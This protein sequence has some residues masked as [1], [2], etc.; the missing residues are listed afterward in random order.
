M[1]TETLNAIERWSSN[2]AMVRLREDILGRLVAPTMLDLQ[3]IDLR[4]KDLRG[5]DFSSSNLRF[6]RLDGSLV[7]A[8]RFASAD[9]TYGSFVEADLS[10]SDFAVASLRCAN[11]AGADLRFASFRDADLFNCILA[12]S[13][14]RAS[15]VR[16]ALFALSDLGGALTAGWR[17]ASEVTIEH[18]ELRGPATLHPRRRE[19]LVAQGLAW[20]ASTIDS[21]L[22]TAFRGTSWQSHAA[23]ALVMAM[24]YR[25]LKL[26]ELVFEAMRSMVRR[27][28]MA[29][30]QLNACLEYVGVERVALEDSKA[31]ERAQ[32]WLNSV[33]LFTETD[34]K[35][36]DCI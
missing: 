21:A 4:G 34:V 24:G 35:N 25:R 31:K 30:P 20:G 32:R 28:S 23:A 11:F 18:W 33:R 2:P 27:N 8:C 13:D 14:L 22:L 15:D 16:G 36:R 6:A 7:A 1:K 12:G 9:L 10:R 29:A 17:T 19:W 3:G 5:L 26:P